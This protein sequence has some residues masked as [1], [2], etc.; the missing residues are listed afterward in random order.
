MLP[1]ALISVLG[2]RVAPT[3]KPQYLSEGKILVESQ[4]IAPD[5]VRPVVTATSNERIQLIQQRVMT[6]D[7]LLSIANKFGLFPQRAGVLDL[8]RESTKIKPVDMDG[9]SRQSANT[10]A[11]T[12]GFEYEDRQLAM[13]VPN[14]F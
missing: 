10:I 11:F 6:R 8:M 7:N 13:R 9:Q 12:V 14:E 4:V 3:K 5:F 2:I 1:F